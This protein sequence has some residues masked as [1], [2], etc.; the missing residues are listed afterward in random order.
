M[1][2]LFM[3]PGEEA[4]KIRIRAGDGSTNNTPVVAVWHG[5]QLV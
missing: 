3:R 5:H 1:P 2:N 4:D